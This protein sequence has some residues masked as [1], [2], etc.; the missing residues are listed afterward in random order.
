MPTLHSK[1]NFR[2]GGSPRSTG[3][4]NIIVIIHRFIQTLLIIT[5]LAGLTTVAARAAED[6]SMQAAPPSSNPDA[7]IQTLKKEVLKL[8]RELFMM[9]EDIL[10]P[11]STQ[12]T[13]FVS[14]DSGE[15]FDLDSV[16]LRIDDKIVAN[17]LYT[18]RELTALKKGGVQRLY[19]GNVKSGDHELTAY[20]IGKGP[21]NRDYKRGVTRTVN[22]ALSPLFVELKIVDDA[23]KEQPDFDLAVWDR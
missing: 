9:E 16:Q 23:S 11:E 12:F 2:R 3:R 4:G 1:I 7:E 15:L 5:T 13:V 18:S 8:N 19:Q 14:L 21:H 17:Y 6:K 22:K 10:Y 20:L